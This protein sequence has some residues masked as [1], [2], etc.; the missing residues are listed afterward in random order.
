[1]EAGLLRENEDLVQVTQR[2]SDLAWIVGTHFLVT[3]AYGQPWLRQNS[4]ATLI[5][6]LIFSVAAEFCSLYRPWRIERLRVEIRSACLTWLIT[7]TSLVTLGFATKTSDKFSR[8]VSFG[9]FVMAIVVLCA[10]RILVRTMLRI[11]RSGG[12]NTRRAAILGATNGARKLCEQLEQRPWYGI[13]VDAVYDDRPAERREDLSDVACPC[14]GNL[15]ELVRACRSSEIDVVY[16]ALPLRAEARIAEAMRVLADTTATVYLVADF[17]AYDLI[18]AQLSAIGRVPLISLHDTPFHGI[19]LGLKRLEDIVVGSLILSLIA[20]PMAVISLLIKLTSPGPIFFRQR[21]YGLNAKEI[22][23]LKFRTMT[24][25]EDGPEITQ[26]KRGDARVTRLG[27]FLRRT[28]LDELPQFLQVITGQMSIVGP[29]PHAV[30]HNE[31][32]RSLIPG[33]MLRHKVKPGITGWAQVN[34]WRG[35]TPDVSYMK[36][37]V[38]HDLAYIGRWTVLWDLK[39]ILLTIFGRRKSQNAY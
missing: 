11:L 18:G 16:V 37:R 23:I 34:G 25:C 17:F 20:L 29:R 38:E 10:W 24:V 21:R 4:N 9:W 36:M 35:E 1:M 19:G 7:V 28:S 3:Y 2:L 13:H 14:R 27:A 5:A 26:A 8:V 33:Y 30:A 12:R 15:A 31:S 39:I 22:R 32:Y 6:V